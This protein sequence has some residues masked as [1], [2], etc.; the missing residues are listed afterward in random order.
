MK[1]TYLE[2]N[3]EISANIYLFIETFSGVIRK[4]KRQFY[5]NDGM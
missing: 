2:L 3:S 5:S 4:L 1:W